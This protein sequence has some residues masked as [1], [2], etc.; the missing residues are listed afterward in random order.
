MAQ[1][2]ESMLDHEDHSDLIEALKMTK[3]ISNGFQDKAISTAGFFWILNPSTEG[4]KIIQKYFESGTFEKCVKLGLIKY[5][6]IIE[7]AM[8]KNNYFVANLALEYMIAAMHKEID[9]EKLWRIRMA[10]QPANL[11]RLRFQAFRTIPCL[12]SLSFWFWDLTEK[13]SQCLYFMASTTVSSPMINWDI[14]PWE[15]AITQYS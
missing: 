7:Y 11:Q 6:D 15:Q 1:L 14:G 9:N 2:Y 3:S 8:I 4:N 5:I 10:H 13:K 12:Q